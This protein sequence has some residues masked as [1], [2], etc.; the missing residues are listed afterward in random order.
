MIWQLDQQERKATCLFRG[1]IR[2]NKLSPFKV[3]MRRSMAPF[4]GGSYGGVPT[5]L[6]AT[7]KRAADSRISLKTIFK[8]IRLTLSPDSPSD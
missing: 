6:Q 8:L 7:M 5:P 1:Y 3:P 4:S 2:I